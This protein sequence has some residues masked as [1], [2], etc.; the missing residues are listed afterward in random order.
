MLAPYWF[1]FV[2]LCPPLHHFDSQQ[3]FIIIYEFLVESKPFC[4]KALQKKHH[5][6]LVLVPHWVL[7]VFI[8]S[9]SSSVWFTTTFY[10]HSRIFS[11]IKTFC[12]K[13]LQKKH[14]ITL[15]LAPYCVLFDLL[16]Q[17]PHQFDSQQPF[18]ITYEFLV[19][20][21]S[22]VLTTAKK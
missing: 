9:S 12:S 15:V 20:T 17:L 16:C 3:P 19:K 6:T 5:I 2:L 4:S 14:H 8:V 7:F 13:A 11:I 18:T 10:N 21:K 1:L 22:F